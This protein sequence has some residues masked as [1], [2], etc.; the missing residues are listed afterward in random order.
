MNK[1]KVVTYI[2]TQ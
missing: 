1:V 2:K